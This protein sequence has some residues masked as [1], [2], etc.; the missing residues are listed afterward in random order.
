MNLLLPPVGAGSWQLVR[1]VKLPRLTE[2]V[3]HGALHHAA[4][5]GDGAG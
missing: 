5:T 3:R 1:A 2:G 4:V